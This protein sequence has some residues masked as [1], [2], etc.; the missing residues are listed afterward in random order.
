M[1]IASTKIDNKVYSFKQQSKCK[2]RRSFFVPGFFVDIWE[3]DF[4]VA[5]V[6]AI[7][8]C[9]A[10]CIKISLRR[11]TVREFDLI[12]LARDGL[13]RLVKQFDFNPVASL[14]GRTCRVG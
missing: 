6:D 14:C 1:G 7:D 8:P 5:G 9:L 11:W 10:F 12:L 13:A 4:A 3:R 2:K